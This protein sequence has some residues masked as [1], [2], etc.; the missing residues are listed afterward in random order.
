MPIFPSEDI[1]TLISLCATNENFYSVASTIRKLQNYLEENSSSAS[2]SD[3]LKLMA[4]L[5]ENYLDE[6]KKL[7]LRQRLKDMISYKMKDEYATQYFNKRFS[8][9]EILDLLKHH[10]ILTGKRL[11][12]VNVDYDSQKFKLGFS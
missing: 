6:S 12:L 2:E 11:I 1:E 10:Q 3:Y 8:N 4:Y 9:A 5:L 7:S